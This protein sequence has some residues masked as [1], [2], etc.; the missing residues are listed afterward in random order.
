MFGEIKE[1][2]IIQSLHSKHIVLKAYANCSL[3]VEFVGTKLTECQIFM[4]T[5]ATEKPTII[6]PEPSVKSLEQTKAVETWGFQ[7]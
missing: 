1:Q 3:Q 6:L 2:L 5:V 4:H 7:Y